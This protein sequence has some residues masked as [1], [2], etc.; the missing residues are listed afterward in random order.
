M[1]YTIL[2]FSEDWS[3]ICQIQEQMIGELTE[4]IEIDVDV[5]ILSPDDSRS[6]IQETEVSAIPTTIVGKEE[7]SSFNK[8]DTFVGITDKQKIKESIR[9]M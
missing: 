4:D 6:I 7:V 2:L 3:Q 1:R 9:D 8:K 5:R